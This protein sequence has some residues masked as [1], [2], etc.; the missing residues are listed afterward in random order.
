MNNLTRIDGPQKSNYVNN[1]TNMIYT[2]IL[3]MII[4]LF[5]IVL[6]PFLRNQIMM[7]R[8]VSMKYYIS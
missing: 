2:Q 7:F 3:A 1:D 6:T 8:R 4:L 5:I